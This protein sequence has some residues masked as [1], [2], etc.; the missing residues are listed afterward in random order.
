[1]P[2]GSRGTS[3]GVYGHCTRLHFQVFWG[4][5]WFWRRPLADL[6]GL[7][8]MPFYKQLFSNH[9][10][11]QVRVADSSSQPSKSEPISAASVC[12]MRTWSSQ[13]PPFS[14]WVWRTKQKRQ[15]CSYTWCLYWGIARPS[16]SVREGNRNQDL[17]KCVALVVCHSPLFSRRG[18]AGAFS[19]IVF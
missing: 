7:S 6:K 4:S 11:A 17:D 10:D 2:S 15:H 3:H 1:M 16:F 8:C 5:A 13:R 14:I 19:W 9:L 12:P 18:I